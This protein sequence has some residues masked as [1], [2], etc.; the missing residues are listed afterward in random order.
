MTVPGAGL[1]SH[2]PYCRGMDRRR[3]LL[4][5][6]VGAVAAPLGAEA[7]Q[8]GRVPVIGFLG[9][10]LPVE[11]PRTE[12][13]RQFREG[14]RELGYVEGTSVQIEWRLSNNYDLYP[15]LAAELVGLNVD[16]L[17]T[18]NTPGALAAKRATT[19][20]PIVFI[21]VGDPVA[22][23]LA[24]TLGRPG[25]NITGLSVFAT[26]LT[27]KRLAL[28]KE[29]SPKAARVAL[30]Y[31]SS[32]P[33]HGPIVK[34]AQAAGRPLSLQVQLW[35][36]RKTD[37]FDRTFQEISTVRADWLMVAQ[38]AF[39]WAN[40][41]RID[42]FALMQRLPTMYEVRECVDAGG[43]M[44]YGPSRSYLFRRAS[45]Y[46][47]RILKGAKPADLPIEQPTKFELI[48]NL[49]TAKALGLT[50]PPSL[51]ARADQVIE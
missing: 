32:N 41:K 10:S 34:E 35:A 27:T 8:A 30:L 11:D 5:S 50:I 16:V 7:Q 33:V 44:S 47:D 2:A 12:N 31:N 6:L 48:I 4:T 49:K 17:V 25:G 28:L 22:V 45:M 26:D 39:L 18:S 21:T 38:D 9:P 20:L 13:F 37:E 24:A 1:G 42:D 46:V 15:R 19:T 40:Q 36:V 14:L 51:L 43:L 29:A 23:G 3:F